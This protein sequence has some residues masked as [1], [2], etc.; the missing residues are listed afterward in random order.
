M[1]RIHVLEIEDNIWC[2]DV[3]ES[4]A[5]LPGYQPLRVVIRILSTHPHPVTVIYIATLLPLNLSVISSIV[6]STTLLVAAATA[7]SPFEQIPRGG[8]C[9]AR[10]ILNPTL[11]TGPNTRTNPYLPFTFGRQHPILSIRRTKSTCPWISTFAVLHAIMADEQPPVCS[12]C[13]LSVK[14]YLKSLHLRICSI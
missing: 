3:L 8:F 2:S 13:F 11:D 6:L 7:R 5:T 12:H 9:Q 14:S 4:R 10:F 1:Q